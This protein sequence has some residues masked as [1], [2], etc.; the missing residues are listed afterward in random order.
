MSQGKAWCADRESTCEYEKPAS[1]AQAQTRP[2][3]YVISQAYHCFS[4]VHQEP[5]VEK[6]ARTLSDDVI[7]PD[8]AIDSFK[9][10]VVKFE[11]HSDLSHSSPFHNVP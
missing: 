10:Y 9:P 2:P 11:H 8:H 7:A 4:E 5:C 3:G 1:R 6:E